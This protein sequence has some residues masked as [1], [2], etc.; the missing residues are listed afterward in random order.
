MLN[1]S[2]KNILVGSFHIRLMPQVHMKSISE[3]APEAFEQKNKIKE[4]IEEV[5]IRLAGDSGDGMQLTGGQFTSTTALVGNDLSTMPDF[6]AEIRA[7]A[8]TV[9]GV[10]GF[11]IHFSSKDIHTPGDRP[12]VLVAMNPAALKANLGDISD[13][14]ILV[15][16]EDAFVDSNI[17]K[18]GYQSNPM[19]DGSL[20]KYRVL[21]VAVSK[22]T[23]EALKDFEISDKDK[24]RCKNMFALGLMYWMFDRPLD[25]TVKWLNTKFAKKPLIAEAN[26][27]TLK[28]GIHFG[29]TTELLPVH[30]SIHKAEIAPGTYRNI[31]GNEAI[32]LGILA[33]SELGGAETFLASYPITPA[34]D[35]LHQVSKYDNF[36]VKIF[37]AEDEIA[38]VCAAIGAAYSGSLSV[39]TTSGP[40]MALKSEGINLAIM[41]ELPLVIIDVQRGGPSTGLPT[42]TEQTDLL[43]CVFGRNG[44]SPIVVLAANSP[45]DCF[46]KTIEAFRIAV[47]YMTPV[48]LLSE[49]FLANGSEPWR[50]PTENELPRFKAEC[51]TETENFQPYSRDE[52]LAR[53]WVKPGTPGLEH[54]I[55]GLEKQD[56]TGNVSYDPDNHEYMVQ[57]RAAK[58]AKVADSIP[59][60]EVEGSGNGQ[61]L[62]ISWGGT[63]GTAIATREG[64]AEEGIGV[65]HIQVDYL[66]PFPKNLGDIIS[67]YD[68]VIVVELNMGQLAYMI[69]GTFGT[70][71]EK[72]N[73]IKGKPFLVEEV[74]DGVKAIL[75][76]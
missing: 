70:L 58:V 4:N 65:D 46:Y 34:S 25:A 42:K 7:P 36:E 37:Q 19:E 31:T 74:I 24:D 48:I 51:Y 28:A 57:T 12:D 40:G 68:K 22:L 71:V 13:N 16:N 11:Q 8:G 18:A 30:F 43:Q 73:K 62:I 15:L 76:H 54:R 53:P 6:P 32:S 59:L 29:E 39:T 66:N 9:A 60:I 61:A 50:L 49:S 44:E 2:R 26:I 35:I 41:A 47:E 14:G 63:Y 69:Q 1:L 75:K 23:K 27:A 10:S 56:L 55:G 17:Q 3:I 45:G 33:A 72:I 20:E 38:A 64:L 52:N 67:N 5:T 21:S